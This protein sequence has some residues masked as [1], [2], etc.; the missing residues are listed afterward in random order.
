VPAL[1]RFLSVDPIE[2]GVTNSYDYPADPI[3]KFDLTGMMTADSAM[4]YVRRGYQVA[5]IGGTIAAYKPGGRSGGSGRTSAHTAQPSRLPPVAPTGMVLFASTQYSEPQW[6]S[7]Q[8]YYERQTVGCDYYCA[9]TWRTFGLIVPDIAGLAFTFVCIR[10]L[11]GACDLDPEGL[12]SSGLGALD[13][14]D[15]ELQLWGRRVTGQPLFYP[16][17]HY[18]LG[19]Y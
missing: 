9:E 1:G 18:P 6:I 16:Y 3:N 4:E 8:S 2:G 19:N 15:S 10:L 17:S 5:T 11:K 7:R 12:A 13:H 14:V